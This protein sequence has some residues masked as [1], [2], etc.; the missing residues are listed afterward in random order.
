MKMDREPLG[1]VPMGKYEVR[2]SVTAIEPDTLVE[3][4]I[5]SG[6][7]GTIGHVYGFRIEPAGAESDVV[8]YCDWSGIPDSYKSA[9]AWPI[10]PA[11]M[12]EQSLVNLEAIVV[13]AAG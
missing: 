10:V 1:D 6:E 8:N 11:S 7:Y 2:C 5:E 12:L 3:W 4:N 13:R 9:V